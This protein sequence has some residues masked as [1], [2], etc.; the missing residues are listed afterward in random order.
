MGTYRHPDKAR[1]WFEEKVRALEGH[2][3]EKHINVPQ[4][5]KEFEKEV[6]YKMKP[7]SLRYQLYGARRRV[8]GVGKSK[9]HSVF[10][11]SKF[12]LV[13]DEQVSGFDTSSEV[14]E[15]IST[16]LIMLR[17]VIVFEKKKIEVDY[18]IDIK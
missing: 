8:Y 11:R 5:C 13:V 2:I 3:G 16:N 18:K 1:K 7:G 10:L 14:K 4:L 6:G 17:D 12:L 15:F 9:R